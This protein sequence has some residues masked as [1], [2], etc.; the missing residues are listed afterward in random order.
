MTETL[1]DLHHQLNTELSRVQ[2]AVTEEEACEDI[3]DVRLSGAAEAC[4]PHGTR[5]TPGRECVVYF[6]NCFFFIFFVCVCVI[7]CDIVC[8]I[9]EDDGWLVLPLRMC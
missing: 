1:T 2:A 5:G 4:T 3:D 9:V 8:V 7:V 6:L